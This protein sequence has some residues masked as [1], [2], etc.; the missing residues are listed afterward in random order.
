MSVN[1]RALLVLED[2]RAFPGRSCGAEGETFGEAVFNT[3]LAG[4]QEVLTDPSY[5]GQIVAMTAPHIGNTGI[6]P[7]DG[8]SDRI[9]V[10]GLV[11]RRPLATR[12]GARGGS[13]RDAL[14]RR[15]VA[16]EERGHPRLTFTCRAVAIAPP[17]RRSSSTGPPG[18]QSG[19]PPE[20]AST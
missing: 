2:G 6:V 15:L 13:L 8:E 12:A 1:A 18:A 3:A 9:Q 16:I 5:C 7:C 17:S 4:Y 20:S 10:A 19:E 14:V 11:V